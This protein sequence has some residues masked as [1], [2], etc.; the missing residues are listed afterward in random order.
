MEYTHCKCSSI[1]VEVVFPRPL[2]ALYLSLQVPYS[3]SSPRRGVRVAG[4][5][6]KLGGLIWRSLIG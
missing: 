2:S 6:R 3:P 4:S 5:D 1:G